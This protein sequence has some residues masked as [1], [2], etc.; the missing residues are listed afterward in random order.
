MKRRFWVIRGHTA[1]KLLVVL[2]GVFFFVALSHLD[3]CFRLL[4]RVGDVFHPILIGLALAYL[5]DPLARWLE[6]RRLSRRAA[7]WLAFLFFLIVCG[8][9]LG[10]GLPR[11]FKS[12]AALVASVPF[13]FSQLQELLGWAQANYGF[14]ASPILDFM[15][16][17]VGFMDRT[18]EWALDNLPLLLS[19]GRSLAGELVDFFTGLILAVYLLFSKNTLFRQCKKTV[20]A[21]CPPALA[22][23][24]FHVCG[25][26]ARML[27]GFI[28]GKILESMVIWFFCLL[29]SSLAGIPYASLMSLV[30]GLGNIVPVLGPLAAGIFCCLILLV[31][32]PFKALVFAVILLVLQQADSKILS[33]LILGDAT[34]L[35]T[36]W[37]LVAILAGGRVAGVPGMILGVPVFAT[38]YTLGREW[39][40]ERLAR[41]GINYRGDPVEEAEPE[42]APAPPPYEETFAAARSR[43]GEGYMEVRLSL[44][45]KT[46][47]DIW[48]DARSAL[49]PGLESLA[50][51]SRQSPQPSLPDPRPAPEETDQT[52]PSPEPSPRETEPAGPQETR[53]PPAPPP[54]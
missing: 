50:G 2:W 18:L 22:R 53:Q 25:T 40:D 31:L 16:T 33:P 43:A 54:S 21:L 14:D 13:Y 49:A 41:K 3:L 34:G 36:F 15:G 35:K 28:G 46:L 52:E 44:E 5:I 30:V 20:W 11:L 9:M 37:V 27:R 6:A 39:M 23:R 10:L 45:E 8:A 38:L 29:I 24:I 26:A 47:T 48:G 17:Y 32:N 51:L 7:V 4:G 42:A 12:L 19:Y 1:S